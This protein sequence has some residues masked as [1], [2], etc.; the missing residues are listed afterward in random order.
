M[1]DVERCK[2]YYWFAYY[3]KSTKDFYVRSTY[4]TDQKQIS[5]HRFVMNCPEDKII[6]HANHITLDNRKNN[7]KICSSAENAE[8]RKQYDNT[9][10][11]YRNVYKTTGSDKYRVQI[12]KG[13]KFFTP[14]KLFDTPEQANEVAIKM[15]NELF[16]NN[17]LDRLDEDSQGA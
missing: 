17:V 2:E 13:A 10:T 5:L 9:A 11:G 6:D 3:C 4:R 8:N 12:K 15:R 1:D 14:N 7:L 16:T